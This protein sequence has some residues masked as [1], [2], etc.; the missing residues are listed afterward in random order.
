MGA[1]PLVGKPC[2]DNW[3]LALYGAECQERGLQGRKKDTAEAGTVQPR[4]RAHQ[5][6]GRQAAS[7]RPTQWLCAIGRAAAPSRGPCPLGRR[8]AGAF[9]LLGRC[10]KPSLT[11]TTRAWR[12]Y[13]PRFIPLPH[14]SPRN[15]AW[16]KQHAWF[17]EDL[18]PALQARIDAMF[19]S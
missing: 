3:M 5:Q 19:A 10:R 17:E 8:L 11:E 18:V 15:Q 6:A 9:A 13:A 2:G 12:E 7:L 14:P 1:S 16:F 4:S